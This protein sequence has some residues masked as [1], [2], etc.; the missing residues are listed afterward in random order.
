MRLAWQ[1]I[2]STIIS[3]ILCQNDLDGVVI[4]TEHG[5]FNTETLC[6]CIQVV[7]L[8]K[9]K[10]FVRLTEINKPLVRIC[11][12]MGCDGLIFS[13]IESLSDAN[14]VKDY[15]LYP[16]SN[17]KRGLGLVRENL[18]GLKSIILK[19][20]PILIAQIETKAGV[21]NIEEIWNSSVFD[22]C[23]IGPYDLSASVGSPGNFET[24]EYTSAVEIVKNTVPIDKMAVHIPTNV[25][26]EKKKYKGYGIMALGMD[27]TSIIEQ[28][29]EINNA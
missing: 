19:S 22:L 14:L 4:D 20:D 6:A 24:E 12:D 23:M 28:Y 2:P 7:T 27:T 21:K 8:S 29:K 3:E 9:K 15:S 25:K 5:T 18:W 17:G 16:S 26:N 1:Q 11:L 13:T 10:C